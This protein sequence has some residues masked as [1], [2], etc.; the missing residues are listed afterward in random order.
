M[1]DIIFFVLGCIVGFITSQHF[2]KKQEKLIA[3]YVH[4][5]GGDTAFVFEYED[6][7]GKKRFSKRGFT[8]HHEQPMVVGEFLNIKSSLIRRTIP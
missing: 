4:K 6:G 1:S 5:D 3:S 2:H 7:Y 8:E